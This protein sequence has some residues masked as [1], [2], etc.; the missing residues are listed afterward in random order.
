MESAEVLKAAQGDVDA[1][2][3]F[4]KWVLD[5]MGGIVASTS[6]RNADTER[7]D[8]IA[9]GVL[10]CLKGLGAFDQRKSCPLTYFWF[11]GSNAM[12]NHLRVRGRIAKRIVDDLDGYYNAQQEASYGPAFQKVVAA[13]AEHYGI[14]SVELKAVE[15]KLSGYTLKEIGGMLSMSPGLVRIKLNHMRHWFDRTW[16]KLAAELGGM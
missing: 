4:G 8:L 12:K 6:F 13:V 2:E 14:D 11:I 15:A 10:C 5:L 7:D 9:E 16:P 3:V 1:L